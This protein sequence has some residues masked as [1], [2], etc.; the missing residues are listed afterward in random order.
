MSNIVPFTITRAPLFA[1]LAV[2]ALALS[3]GAF[4]HGR[5]KALLIAAASDLKFALPPIVSRFESEFAQRVAV[6][7]GSSGNMA[8][9][10]QQG[11]PF[12]LF[13]SADEALVHR[14]VETGHAR[15]AGFVYA[16]GRLA[17]YVSNASKL[18]P[19][20][21]LSDLQRNWKA[22]Q[23]FAIANPE[24]A[25]YGRAASEALESLGLSALVK[26]KTVYGENVSQAAQFI[27]T[28]AAQAGL[29]ALSLAV[30]P[31]LARSGR[32]VVLPAFRHQPL[33]QRVSLMRHAGP[34]AE[35][36]YEFLQRPDTRESLR[37]SGFAMPSE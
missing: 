16:V 15:D 19:D 33:R 29:I 27:S 3:I 5:E 28:G 35:H 14:L 26:P 30:A 13:F 4:A 31:E 11:A 21:N 7:L 1:R 20:E 23:K 2:A 22:V 32:Y 36:F 25:P 37:Q 24:H 34:T 17:L 12:E 8:R 9:Q 6:T 18:A 10:I